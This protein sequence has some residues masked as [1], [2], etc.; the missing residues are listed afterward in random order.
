M[1]SSQNLLFELALEYTG[2]VQIVGI[3][4]LAILIMKNYDYIRTVS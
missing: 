3:F 2:D 4:Q 1:S